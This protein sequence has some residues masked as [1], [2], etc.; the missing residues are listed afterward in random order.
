VAIAG[1][2]PA[3][4]LAGLELEVTAQF[5]MGP[6][7]HFIHYFVRDQRLLCFVAIVEQDT[8]TRES[9]TRSTPTPDIEPHVP[10]MN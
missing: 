2:V 10:G 1:L 9:W 6:G 4:R 3:D 7:R 5:W 8:W